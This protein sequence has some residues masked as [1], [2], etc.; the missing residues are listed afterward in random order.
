MRQVLAQIAEKLFILFDTVRLMVNFRI[1][2]VFIVAAA[3]LAG[4]TLSTLLSGP[5]H[6]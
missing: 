4:L 6:I 3:V 1:L 2:A 5:P